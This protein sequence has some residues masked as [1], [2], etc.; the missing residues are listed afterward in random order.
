MANG[1]VVVDASGKQ[2]RY[3]ELIGGKHFNLT[4]DR[5]AKRR[6]QRSGPFWAS[7]SLAGS[8]PP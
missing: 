6:P 2:V 7:R 1:V 3:E 5:T 8:V 4:L